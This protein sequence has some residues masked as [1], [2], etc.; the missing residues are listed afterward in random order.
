MKLVILLYLEDDQAVVEKI[1]HD[2]GVQAFSSLP[3]TGHG[4]GAA[5]WYGQVAPYASRMTFTLIPEAR[6]GELLDAV[7]TAQGLQD[8]A[9]P[10][11]AL[12]VD[13]EKAVDSGSPITE[14]IDSK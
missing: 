3:V 12:Q 10:L 11:H 9:H 14:R 5:G 8:P 13:V 2:H 6:A 4:A 7:K 1:L